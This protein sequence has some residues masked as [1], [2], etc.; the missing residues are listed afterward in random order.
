MKMYAVRNENRE[1][2]SDFFPNK[3]AA[4]AVRNVMNADGKSAYVT[5]GPDHPRYNETLKPNARKRNK[6]NR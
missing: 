3:M 2:V 4:K 5:N 6:R 1:V